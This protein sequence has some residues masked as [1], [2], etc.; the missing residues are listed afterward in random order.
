MDA[1][2]DC[3]A[4]EGCRRRR[5]HRRARRRATVSTPTATS[6]STRPSRAQEGTRTQYSRDG[7]ALDS[8]F[9]V[10]NER[11]YPAFLHLVR[12]LGVALRPSTMSFSV[13]CERCD[14]EFSG[15]G[16]GGL[17]AQRR[18]LVRPVVRPPAARSR[19]LLPQRPRRCSPIRG[20][21]SHDRRVPRARGLRP[22]ADRPLPG[23]DGRCDLVLLAGPDARDARALLHPLLRQP[24]TAGRAR[25]AAVVHDR[26]RLAG[27]R[28]GAH[29][30]ACAGGVALAHARSQHSRARAT[31]SS[32][33][34]ATRA[35][36]RFD[37]LI[38]ACHP[39]QA[40]ALL[41]DPSDVERDALAAHA[42][43]AQRDHR[44]PRRR[45]AAAARRGARG[46][47]RR[48][49]RLP[50]ARPAGQRDL[51]AQPPARLRGPRRVLRLAE[52]VG[53]H[54]RT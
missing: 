25:R 52:P 7:H 53:A 3:G 9:V 27:L 24:W 20:R 32:C 4:G 5:R 54:R 19:P 31:A 12:D 17:F 29:R 49:R 37:R 16:L 34:R 22:G 40:L 48:A 46:L 33:A 41:E 42:V 45:A 50:R 15:H 23:A 21:R 13:R 39:D 30:R 44:P 10:C 18:N 11:N 14:L 51:L 28:R 47:E 1:A 43:L 38:L 35:P 2:A 36:E 8:G 26:G 6:C